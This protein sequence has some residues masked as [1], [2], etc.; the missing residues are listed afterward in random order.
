M[1]FVRLSKTI[2]PELKNHIKIL[3]TKIRNLPA[4]ENIGK[5]IGSKFETDHGDLR[6]LTQIDILK[7]TTCLKTLS[8]DSI[9]VEKISLA[10]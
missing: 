9:N 1:S 8:L 4:N 6:N 3:Q 10:K 2:S 7:K 5:V